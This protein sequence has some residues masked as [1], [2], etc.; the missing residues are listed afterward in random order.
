MARAAKKARKIKAKAAEPPAPDPLADAR[1]AF[2]KQGSDPAIAKKAIEDAAG[3][4]RTLWISFLT[5]GTY[6]VITVSAVTHEQLFHETPI[7]LPLLN[8]DL[9]LVAFFWVTPILFLIFHL[10]LLLNLKLLAD[11][12][13]HY[14]ELMRQARVKEA[15]QNRARLQL[16]NFMIVQMIGGHYEQRGVFASFALAMA[17]W[18]TLIAAPVILILLMQLQFLPYH[19][20]VVTWA[21]RVVLVF[22]FGLVWW[23]W[24]SVNGGLSRLA[25]GIPPLATLVAIYLSWS[26]M[27]FPGEWMHGNAPQKLAWPFQTLNAETSR[28]YTVHEAMFGIRDGADM[29]AEGPFENRLVYNGFKT[30]DEQKINIIAEKCVALRSSGRQ[31]RTPQDYQGLRLCETIIDLTHRH[32]EEAFFPFI[33]LR[34]A[35]LFGA[36]LPGAVLVRA[37]LSGA[38]LDSSN[39]QGASLVRALLQDTRLEQSHL[40]G[41]NL[42]GAELQGARLAEAH[43]QGAMLDEAKLQLTRLT[44]SFLQGTSLKNAK[45]HGTGLASAKLQGTALDGAQMQCSDLR[46]TRL[47]GTSL[48][49]ASVAGADFDSANFSGASLANTQ[50]WRAQVLEQRADLHKAR[51]I[52]SDSPINWGPK[53]KRYRLPAF[54]D[55]L[56]N[57]EDDAL[58]GATERAR[59]SI[60]RRLACLDF[61]AQ[62]PKED[63]ENRAFWQTAARNSPDKVSFR[64]YQQDER[65]KAA[66]DPLGAPHSAR[67][68]IR[69]FVDLNLPK[70][71]DGPVIEKLLDP[72]CLGTKGLSGQERQRLADALDS[73]TKQTE[74]EE[75]AE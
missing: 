61:N 9:P 56:R 51:V 21:H 28:F 12:V 57:I 41:S 65:V 31:D 52:E 10:Y 68:I 36:R 54:D 23:F 33:D 40:E 35:N 2:E 43:L 55:W 14:G 15:Q 62:T 67:G 16:P 11:Q 49:E 64:K 13:H 4:A 3:L 34:Y 8:G 25:R 22:C 24:W 29:W 27:T 30:I 32:F 26:V 47:Q 58:D 50:L 46:Q 48:D 74:G 75:A 72:A 37:N 7:K 60:K 44:G 17:T 20:E 63:R 42:E 38:H 1:A 59:V 19:S 73:L 39:L 6:L 45:M 5:F 53:G 71:T 66:C 69:N 18:I 70:E